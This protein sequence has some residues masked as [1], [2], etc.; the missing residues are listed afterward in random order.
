MKNKKV[1]V[2]VPILWVFAT[3]VW[4]I[5]FIINLEYHGL[6]DTLVILQGATVLV[7]LTAAIVNF[8]RYKKT[9]YTDEN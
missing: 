3:V 5:S 9:K 4:T 7:S 2:I 1:S 8:I 6:S